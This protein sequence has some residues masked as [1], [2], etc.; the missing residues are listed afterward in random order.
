MHDAKA[1]ALP[2]KSDRITSMN[3]ERLEWAA[4]IIKA[5]AAN[6]KLRG[7]RGAIRRQQMK[8]ALERGETPEGPRA[9]WLKETA[10]AVIKTLEAASINFNETN[11]DD[12]ISA[13][14]LGDV[15]I[16]A[17]KWLQASS[18]GEKPTPAAA[19]VV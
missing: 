7:A 13:N 16:T 9:V 15:L 8:D 6:E 1:L 4:D 10:A 18:N 19:P 14:D 12:L 11:L 5:A 17:I 3:K 2:R